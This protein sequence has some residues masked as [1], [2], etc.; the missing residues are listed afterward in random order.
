MPWDPLR[1][2]LDTQER[3]ESLFSRTA[4]GWVPTADLYEVADRYVLTIEVPGLSRADVQI[5][6]HG[7][8][9][10]VRG[11]RPALECPERFHQLERGH[12][13]FARSFRFSQAVRADAITADIADGV[14]TIALPKMAVSDARRI[15]VL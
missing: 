1:D 9:L 5:Q 3:L 7:D 11:E 6:F 8:T 15:D 14:L 12:G 10:V 4:P 2:L 13:P